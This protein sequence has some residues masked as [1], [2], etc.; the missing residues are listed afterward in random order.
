MDFYD[1]IE[2]IREHNITMFEGAD[3]PKKEDPFG[4]G[5]SA[6]DENE[7]SKEEKKPDD[8]NDN[9]KEEKKPD[10]D[11]GNPKG[12][13]KPDGDN[14][15][16]KGE[17]KPDEG[18]GTPNDGAAKQSGNETGK[19]T[20]GKKAPPAT[21]KPAPKKNMFGEVVDPDS[22][23]V[24]KHE[25]PYEIGEDG[26]EIEDDEHLLMLSKSMVQDLN[27]MRNELTSNPSQED[28]DKINKIATEY[29]QKYRSD[30]NMNIDKINSIRAARLGK[31]SWQKSD[32]DYNADAANDDERQS[33]ANASLREQEQAALN[34]MLTSGGKR[35]GYGVDP[36]VIKWRR[37]REQRKASAEERKKNANRAIEG[38][39]DAKKL[40]VS[41]TETHPDV[42]GD[43]YFRQLPRLIER[44]L[45]MKQDNDEYTL[46]ERLTGRNNLH[47]KLFGRLT[48]AVLPG[49]QRGVLSS[50]GYAF[51][52][53]YFPVMEADAA[54]VGATGPSVQ[55]PEKK[56]DQTT[57]PGSANQQVQGAGPT[58]ASGP[59]P[60]VRT[61][62]PNGQK[63]PQEVPAQGAGP[64]GA[65]VPGPAVGAGNPNG[66]KQPQE[67]P[68]QGDG[69]TGS[70]NPNPA[71]QTATGAT[72]PADGNSVS[73]PSGSDNEKSP[74]ELNGNMGK[75]AEAAPT[76][77]Q[78]ETAEPESALAS[79]PAQASPA[80]NGTPE[81]PGTAVAAGSFANAIKIIANSAAYYPENIRSWADKTLAPAVK[82]GYEK[83][84]G[85]AKNDRDRE[86]WQNR[87]D[88][89]HSGLL[90]RVKTAIVGEPRKNVKDDIPGQP[91]SVPNTDSARKPAATPAATPK[92]TTGFEG[93]TEGK[94]EERTDAPETSDSE[95]AAPEQNA[96][97]QNAPNEDAE[98]ESE[99]K[100]ITIKKQDA[101]SEPGQE[102]HTETAGA[103]SGNTPEEKPAQEKQ[104]PANTEKK[105]PTENQ[106]TAV[107][108]AENPPAENKPA[109]DGKPASQGTRNTPEKPVNTSA[110]NNTPP[111]AEQQE[112]RT[113]AA[114]Q[115]TSA[116]SG[117]AGGAPAPAPAA[118]KTEHKPEQSA[119]PASQAASGN[120]AVPAG[121]QGTQ[122][123]RQNPHTDDIRTRAERTA[124]KQKLA[125]RR[126]RRTDNLSRQSLTASVLDGITG[127]MTMFESKKYDVSKLVDALRSPENMESKAERD[128]RIA[129]TC[130]GRT[131]TTRVNSAPA[132]YDR[133]KEKK[134]RMF[135][136][137]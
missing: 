128:A 63:Q 51:G 102:Q 22:P 54:P 57:P 103:A 99:E 40:V 77:P 119:P 71:V 26:K 9:S 80:E 34:G 53:Q 88:A 74:D 91:G 118:S 113:P 93:E 20:E 35:K 45:K 21:P 133:S 97:E 110:G 52:A 131:M 107:T 132:G 18:N 62:N 13:K 29:S 82:A 122:S 66:Q 25:T 72:S 106:R 55:N 126:G 92:E 41:T 94:A 43:W 111:P 7:N 100:K 37:A 6:D 127:D 28:I 109:D 14:D 85:A 11:N 108:G 8:D 1:F 124:N 4:D 86:Y 38:L 27:R 47:P 56:A 101:S 75:D 33:S 42:V 137:D 68:A 36:N 59:G 49:G 115:K 96:P 78:Q 5:F 31:N 79:G 116:P 16:P 73:G 76:G 98:G 58:G 123:A 3:D 135:Y 81:N 19:N 87:A 10:G 95:Q 46:D 70:A 105:A 136:E 12:E 114:P 48:N 23:F 84:A 30:P 121:N 17:K 24:W 50:V 65:S 39:E 125:R 89:V 60:A 83:L 90:S 44:G 69:P 112:T 64:T 130:N 67:V 15:N 61:A 117:N 120:T 32:V 2:N 129:D 134:W 104:V